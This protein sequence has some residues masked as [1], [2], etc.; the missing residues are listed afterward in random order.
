AE[1]ATRLK[2]EAPN[3]ELIFDCWTPLAF[4]GRGYYAQAIAK[5][6]GLLAV[7]G[8]DPWIFSAAT[9]RASVRG[10]DQSGF[11]RRYSLIRHMTLGV[12]SL[13]KIDC[14]TPRA[15]EVPVAS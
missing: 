10:I 9:N 7:E 1:L 15:A 13:S 12:K 11:E 4:R 14:L 3:A 5:L 8:R 6:A 2:S